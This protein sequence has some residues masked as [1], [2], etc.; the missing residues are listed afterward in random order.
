MFNENDL[1]QYKMGRKLNHG[2]NL[3]RAGDAIKMVQLHG[4]VE[5]PER[6]NVQHWSMQSRHEAHEV[7]INF[8]H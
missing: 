8:K 5:G 1:C 3:F 6:D 7:Q 2:S 4:N